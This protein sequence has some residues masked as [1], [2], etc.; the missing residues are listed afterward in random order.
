MN[1]PRNADRRTALHIAAAKGLPECLQ[2]LLNHGANA[3]ATAV[4]KKDKELIPQDLVGKLDGSESKRRAELSVT[5]V[6]LCARQ[7]TS[8]SKHVT[9]F[10]SLMLRPLPKLVSVSNTNASS[11]HNHQHGVLAVT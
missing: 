9:I 7:V 5:S 6:S 8:G 4:N 1:R 2:R 3:T 10:L 11:G